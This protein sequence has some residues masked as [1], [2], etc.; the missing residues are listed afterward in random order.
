MPSTSPSRNYEFSATEN[1]IIRQLVDAM[2][3]VAAASLA[4]GAFVLILGIAGLVTQ[5]RSAVGPALGDFAEAVVFVLI[6]LWL[7]R[8]VDA[9][10]RV[11]DTSGDDI[12]HLLDALRE[13][14][15]VFSL[16]RTV[17]VLAAIVIVMAIGI[18]GVLSLG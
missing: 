2:R 6:G 13:L 1:V 9:F 16:Q 12:T 18:H 4:V 3:F 11:V 7:Q 14:T 5:G 8:A 17:L 10:N 15:R